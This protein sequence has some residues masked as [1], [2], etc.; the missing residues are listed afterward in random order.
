MHIALSKHHEARGGDRAQARETG[1]PHGGRLKRAR[2]AST[3]VWRLDWYR[4]RAE[5]RGFIIKKTIH[6]NTKVRDISPM[7]QPVIGEAFS[8]QSPNPGN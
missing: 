6:K 7:T 3:H 4:P 5:D 2:R 8:L 1:D